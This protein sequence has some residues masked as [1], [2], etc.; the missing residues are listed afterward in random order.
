LQIRR[1][2]TAETPLNRVRQKTN[3]AR[4]FKLIAG[5]SPL[6]Q[7]ISFP[8]FRKLWLCSPIPCP[9]RGALRDRH[10]CWVRDAMDV[11]VRTDE[12]R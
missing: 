4:P 8:F 10:E 11:L 12:T 7:N 9:V 3:F 5:F 6:D 2:G 1:F